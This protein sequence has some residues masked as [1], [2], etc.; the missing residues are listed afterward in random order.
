MEAEM[1]VLVWRDRDAK[2]TESRC[3]NRKNRNI[4]VIIAAVLLLTA[5][6]GG[7]AASAS[8]GKQ[9]EDLESAAQAAAETEE[10]EVK[11]ADAAQIPG[12]E[13]EIAAKAVAE[14]TP[15]V[16]PVVVA[17]EE[18]LDEAGDGVLT[19]DFAEFRIAL[20][21]EGDEDDY[22]PEMNKPAIDN[23]G[24]VDESSSDTEGKTE[25][26]PEAVDPENAAEENAEETTGD[27]T[28]TTD[29]ELSDGTA[30][31]ID[32]E[33][34]PTRFDEIDK[35][36]SVLNPPEDMPS[37]LTYKYNTAMQLNLSS[38]EITVLERI[39]EAEATGED[40]YGR[41]LVANVVINRVNSRYFP[42]TV[43]AVVFEKIGDSVQFSPIKDGRYY[44]VPVTAE[45]KEAVSRVLSG[46]DYSRGALYFFERAR[47]TSSKASWFDNNL[48]YLM[49][50]GCHEFYTERKN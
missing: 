28:D 30:E 39:V 3:K 12:N 22:Y 32:E 38:E 18:Y 7:I 48:K 34:V 15:L 44:T 17:H 40:V 20:L 25:D 9:A 50:Y 2:K 26:D 49:K 41:M 42:N 11:V 24:S 13:T 8:A 47:T 16:T 27:T 4:A 6:V 14:V 1:K 10:T 31:D 45:T 29:V 35:M 37:A 46:E 5:F 33:D 36:V 23:I 43:K 21:S 19:G